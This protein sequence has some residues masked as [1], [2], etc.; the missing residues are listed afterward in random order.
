MVTPEQAMQWSRETG[1]NILPGA[2]IMAWNDYP[3]FFDISK[4]H[5]GAEPTAFV[6]GKVASA[7]AI[8]SADI[9][10]AYGVTD[11]MI[12][13]LADMNKKSEIKKEIPGGE[14][15]SKGKAMAMR[16]IMD[17]QMQ[18]TIEA[19]DKIPNNLLD[20]IARTMPLEDI[21]G[22]MLGLGIH[23]KPSEFQRI[24]IIS[25]G[26][27]K[28]AN[29]LED[30]N[31]VF[32]PNCECE[33]IDMDLRFSDLIGRALMGQLE[34]RSMINVEKRTMEKTAVILE[35]TQLDE[36]SSLYKGLKNK[37]DK[38]GMKI[39]MKAIKSK[40]WI[41]A[42]IGSGI[43]YNILANDRN[44]ELQKILTPAHRYEDVLQ[45]T[46]FSGI[47]KRSSLG[48]SLAIGAIGGALAFPAA[49]MAN[50]YNQRS[51]ATKGKSL[52][53]GAGMKP[54]TM[55]VAAGVGTAGAHALGSKA[56]NV[57]KRLR[58]R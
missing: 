6:L 12:D 15:I 24:V 10:E 58:G 35:P 27:E 40:A 47:E 53:P 3:R 37:A 57:I 11:E 13:K 48:G 2:M 21:F 45:N 14:V 34:K 54:K 28:L 50:S 23:P 56:I 8:A 36:L 32:D 7:K 31:I 49:Y 26:E 18:K 9:A 30:N 52:F 51:L 22:T 55:A 43:L 39:M 29:D 5:V 41:A 16:K 25:L 33:P 17:S 19:E 46:Y 4:V 38:D 44:D 20:P 42:I 1:N